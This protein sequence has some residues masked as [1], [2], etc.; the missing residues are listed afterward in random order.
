MDLYEQIQQKM[1]ELD[2][3]V[4]HIRQT[5]AAYAEAERNYQITLRQEVLKLRDAG[6]AVGIIDLTCRGIPSVADARF[7]RDCEE[8]IYEA[9][10]EACNSIK[11]QLRILEGQL[12]REWGQAK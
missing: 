6:T 2:Y 8:A 3:A 5:G 11:L 12:S 7:K 1:R 4:K 9:C 10:K